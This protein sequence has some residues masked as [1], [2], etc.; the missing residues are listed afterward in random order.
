VLPLVVAV[1]ASGAACGGK[2]KKTGVTTTTAASPEEGGEKK[3]RRGAPPPAATEAAAPQANPRFAMLKPY[4]A[5]YHKRPVDTKT[6]L[7]RNNLAQFA[8]RVE[9]ET[10]VEK[11]SEEPKTPLEYYDAETYRLVLIM[12]GT[13]QAKA[14]VTDP[15]GK[16]FIIMVGTR[17]G[18]R[19]G[20]VASITA[21]EVRVEE[22][23]RQPVIKALEPPTRD[24]EKEL[25][26][27]QEL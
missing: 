10:E 8:P 25:Q 21:T 16:S 24:I 4:F 19:G 5:Q 26:A 27:V 6:N 18:N 22:P 23:G 1:A 20:K 9:I 2:A 14:L 3:R 13:A 12:S 11:P 17:I 15:K 7:F